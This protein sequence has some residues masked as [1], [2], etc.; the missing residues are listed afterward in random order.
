MN[1][2]RPKIRFNVRL[3]SI[4]TSQKCDRAFVS[5][6][7]DPFLTRETKLTEPQKVFIFVKNGRFFEIVSPEVHEK[8]RA[9]C[10]THW[11][12]RRTDNKK[13]RHLDGVL[14]V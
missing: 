5:Y 3:L 9:N 1:V 12:L 6:R 10:R 14:I 7:S 13:P 4:F 2:L 8:F 11:A